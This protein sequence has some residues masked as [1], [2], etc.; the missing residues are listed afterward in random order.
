M[1]P[2]APSTLE[3]LNPPPHLSVLS[4]AG[5]S[6]PV[7][8]NPPYFFFVTCVFFCP[9]PLDAGR[10]DRRRDHHQRRRNHPQDARGRPPCGEGKDKR[11][12]KA[13]PTRASPN[14]WRG[15]LLLLV[16][17]AC[18][19]IET[20]LDILPC[21][22]EIH[23]PVLGAGGKK[24]RVRAHISNLA[25]SL[26]FAVRCLSSGTLYPPNSFQTSDCTTICDDDF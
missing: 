3:A 16:V 11:Q 17:V 23:G 1:I 12:Q 4:S 19:C 20:G 26:F 10:R 2:S 7:P 21:W 6:L 15:V 25:C 18:L 14:E 13:K 22:P 5:F 8:L 24:H 9:G